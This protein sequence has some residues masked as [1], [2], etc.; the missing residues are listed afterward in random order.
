MTLAGGALAGLLVACA[1]ACDRPATKPGASSTLGP[2]DA[3]ASTGLPPAPPVLIRVDARSVIVDDKFFVG[4]PDAW[5]TPLTELLRQKAGIAG[6][7]VALN[8]SPDV[9]IPRVL[10]VVTALEAAHARAVV[11]QAR[12][13]RGSDEAVTLVFQSPSPVPCASMTLEQD[14][15]AVV[16]GPEGP[17][18]H[19][20][21]GADGLDREAIGRKLRARLV[22]C[23]TKPWSIRGADTMPWSIPFE[24]V[25]ELAEDD[26][27]EVGPLVLAP[28]VRPDGGLSRRR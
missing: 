16:A 28:Y 6:A 20:P 24:I 8:V 26:A 19:V 25:R 18:E 2:A 15:T 9:R 17:G 27:G 3:G 14:G 13:R 12:T 22:G 4:S 23:G 7:D 1:C 21:R 11:V 10:G 5:T